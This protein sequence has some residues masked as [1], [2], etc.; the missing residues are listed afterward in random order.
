L[1]VQV[2]APPILPDRRQTP[3]SA[4][5]FTMA[6]ATRGVS[7]RQAEVGPEGVTLT[8]RA[9][10]IIAQKGD[11]GY[12]LVEATTEVVG[13]QAM[14]TQRLSLGVLPPLPFQVVVP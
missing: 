11:T 3:L 6:A 5:R 8:V 14:L 4:V 1:Q 7:V 2:K 10:A 12:L 9:D 13:D